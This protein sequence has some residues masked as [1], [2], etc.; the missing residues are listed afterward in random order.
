MRNEGWDGI[1]G[2]WLGLRT[3]ASRYI[4]C[5]WLRQDETLRQK[6]SGHND[7]DV[8]KKYTHLELGT[9]RT[10]IDSIKS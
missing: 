2:F 10:A 5:D 9:L 8:H 3:G 6:L 4:H 7:A 1:E